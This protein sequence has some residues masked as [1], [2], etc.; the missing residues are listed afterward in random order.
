M[1]TLM[2][3]LFLI[4][5]RMTRFSSNR[6]GVTSSMILV[7]IYLIKRVFFNKRNNT[8]WLMEKPCILSFTV[9]EEKGKRKAF[10]FVTSIIRLLEE[11][12]NLKGLKGGHVG[13]EQDMFA[14][15]SCKHIND[16]LK[17]KA[18]LFPCNFQKLL[19]IVLCLPLV[20]EHD[21]AWK[22]AILFELFP[23]MDQHFPDDT[24][25]SDA[26]PL[27]PRKSLIAQTSYFKKVI[28]MVTN[29]LTSS[30]NLEIK[31]KLLFQENGTTTSSILLFLFH[32]MHSKECGKSGKKKAL[33]FVAETA[34]QCGTVNA[35]RQY[36][37]LFEEFP[38]KVVHAY[39]DSF[40]FRGRGFDE[41]WFHRF[42][43]KFKEKYKIDVFQNATACLHLCTACE[44]LK[45]VLSANHEAPLNTECLMEEKVF[46]R[47]KLTSILGLFHDNSL[48]YEM[49]D[50][51]LMS[52][53][54]KSNENEY[55]IN[56][57]DSSKHIDFSSR[58][59]HICSS[60]Y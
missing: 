1:Y 12:A 52:Y 23:S 53:K 31:V 37:W 21:N 38:P 30:P 56:H 25:L 33:Q 35:V 41:A 6:V 51:S 27:N 46:S 59:G 29:N 14:I 42:A 60:Y 5:W 10:G 55:L 49:T 11:S 28:F 18:E 3:F 48:Y 20:I 2:L 45:K 40:N 22:I 50:E 4:A 16:L 47:M 7:T 44:M 9:V 17:I 54:G 36:L 15:L 8:K 32:G 43:G 24:Y 39:V 13:Q 19:P 57:I 26:L 34:Q 58:G